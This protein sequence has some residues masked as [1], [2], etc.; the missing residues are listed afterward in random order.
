MHMFPAGIER[1]ARSVESHSLSLCA[2]RAVKLLE[3]AS[4]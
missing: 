4:A 1:L 2:D 3:V